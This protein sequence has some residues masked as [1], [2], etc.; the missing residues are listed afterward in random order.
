[1]QTLSEKMLKSNH[2]SDGNFLSVVSSFEP[3][4]SYRVK[5]STFGDAPSMN[6][7]ATRFNPK[8]IALSEV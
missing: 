4:K 8:L 2:F 5:K 3:K 1:V 6:S 7:T